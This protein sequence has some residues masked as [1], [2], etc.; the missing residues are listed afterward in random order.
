MSK[1]FTELNYSLG[2]EDSAVEYH[3][4]PHG[5]R[6]VA[7]VAGS[8]GRILPL[9]AKSPERLC[10]FDILKEQLHLTRLR[11]ESVRALELEEF[12]AFW[13]YPPAPMAPGARK[14]RFR[15]LPLPGDAAE[16]LCTLFER[17]RWTEIIYMGRFERMFKSLVWINQLFT[18][19]AGRGLFDCE[20]VEDQI[21]YLKSSFPDLRWRVVL[22]LLA[23]STVLNSILY[24]GD[25]PRK[26]IPDSTYANFRRIYDHIFRGIRVKE[27]FFAQFSF[28]GRLVTREA[29]LM[30]VDPEIFDSIKYAIPYTQVEYV[31]GDIVREI[32]SGREGYNFVSLSDVPS[33][34]PTASEA[35]YLRDM[36]PGLGP[37]AIVVTRGNLRVITPEMLG[38]EDISGSLSELCSREKTQLWHVD[39]FKRTADH[40]P[41]L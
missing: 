33:F 29:G 6:R 23:N 34:L 32:A 8:G 36:R 3:L 13:G 10:C 2:D 18:G 35:L 27:S 37:G 19:R 30:E 17:H 5:A 28:F 21:E 9:L 38:Y 40:E 1:Y 14:D 41:Y 15:S 24:K 31:H 16:S 39:A 4:L 11:V 12:A 26:N 22:F 20:T 25:F 7:A